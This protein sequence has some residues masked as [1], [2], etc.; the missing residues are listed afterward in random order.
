MDVFFGSYSD[1]ATEAVAYEMRLA[2]AS[3]EIVQETASVVVFRFDQLPV[4]LGALEISFQLFSAQS[5]VRFQEDSFTFDSVAFSIKEIVNGVSGQIRSKLLACNSWRVSGIRKDVAGR[6][7]NFRSKDLELFFTDAV[8]SAFGADLGDTLAQHGLPPVDLSGFDLEFFVWVCAGVLA[9]G[10]SDRE[11]TGLL[12]PPTR[13]LVS[14]GDTGEILSKSADTTAYILAY[15]ALLMFEDG[16]GRLTS[17]SKLLCGDPMCGV[18]TCLFALQH[19]ISTRF[20]GVLAHCIGSDASEPSVSQALANLARLRMDE[21]R[22]TFTPCAAEEVARTGVMPLNSVDIVVVDPPWGHRHGSFADISR[23]TPAW[24]RQWVAMLRCAPRRVRDSG[25][26]L[27]SSKSI[28]HPV[29][30]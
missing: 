13:Q 8:R 23:R 16:S 22:F 20:Q 12:H 27:H 1:G 19:I 25:P 17:G 5:T 11:L 3:I 29:G 18:G 28:S 26:S 2:R 6:R 15:T 30:G 14:K 4:A 21:S 10:W 9:V 24:A 7:Q